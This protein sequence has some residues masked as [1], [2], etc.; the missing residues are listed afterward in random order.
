MF[1]LCFSFDQ[2]GIKKAIFDPPRPSCHLEFG[3]RLFIPTCLIC[4]ISWWASPLHHS[5][6]AFLTTAREVVKTCCIL[7]LCASA[8][9]GIHRS[10]ARGEKVSFASHSKRSVV[11]GPFSDLL[12][13]YTFVSV[14]L[15][16][17]YFACFVQNEGLAR[18]S[19]VYVDVLG[20]LLMEW[21]I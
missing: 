5:Q 9:S 11:L 12:W 2:K 20:Q 18:K 7:L 15:F 1:H 3:C 10:L 8:E 6:I 16:L 21:I 4:Y 14:F 13:V 17:I 19:D